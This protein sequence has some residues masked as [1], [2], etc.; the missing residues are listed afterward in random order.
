MVEIGPNKD[1]L[2]VPGGVIRYLCWYQENS[3]TKDTE[4]W[5]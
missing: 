2:P 3:I 4:E 5:I 1:I